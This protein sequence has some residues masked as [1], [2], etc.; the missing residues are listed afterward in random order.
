MRKTGNEDINNLCWDWFTDS[1]SHMTAVSGPL[2]Q[3]KA[4]HFAKQLG[5]TTLTASNGWLDS[6][7]KRNNLGGAIMAG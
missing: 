6:F 5:N 7:K 4:L 1:R 2:L 3:E